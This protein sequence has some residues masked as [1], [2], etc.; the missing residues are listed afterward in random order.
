MSLV[1]DARWLGP[2]GIGRYAKEIFARLP[3][4]RALSLVLPTLHPLD[5]IELS[6]RLWLERPD[7][8]FSPGFNP[9][10]SSPC[11]F[12]FTIHDLI[13]LHLSGESS[14]FKR[15]YY[16]FVVRPAAH[17]ARAVLTDS[18]FSRGQILEWSGLS[19]DRVKVVW[20]GV[21]ETFS[22]QGEVYNPGFPYLFTVVND[23]LHKNFA[24]LL[25]AFARSGLAQ[26]IKLIVNRKPDP[27][28]A[29]VAELGLEGSV[30]FQG[31][32]SD[33]EL[34][35]FYRG[36]TAFVFPSLYEGFGLPPLEAMACGVPVLA[37]NRTS[38]PEV[39]GDAGVLIDPQ[40]LEVFA[41]QLRRIVEDSELRK[42]LSMDGPVRAKSFTWDR[43][44]A[45][46]R[47]ALGI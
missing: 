46:V 23:K 15:A 42:R 32:I 14:L 44:G 8:F 45:L 31:M 18:E 20:C 11:P 9:P 28:V 6:A 5:P 26:E 22:P 41:G 43:T 17:R 7:L 40:D 1:V 13:H 39:V 34:P 21:D 19:A 24:G 30:V 10:V 2:H 37:S 36:A 33:A 38:I 47:S 12:V 29:R 35:S 16:Q 25:E 3:N 27:W 4:P